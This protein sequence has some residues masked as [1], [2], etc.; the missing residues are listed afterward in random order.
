MIGWVE[1]TETS[2]TLSNIQNDDHI[3][4]MYQVSAWNAGGE[5]ELSEPLQESTP[6]GKQGLFEPIWP[7]I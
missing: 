6:Q 4:P 7:C 2:F 5:G 1:K 3:C